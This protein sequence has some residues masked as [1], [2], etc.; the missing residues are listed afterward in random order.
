METDAINPKLEPLITIAL[1]LLGVVF[2]TSY[3]NDQSTHGAGPIARSVQIPGLLE[4]E[5]LKVLGKSRDFNFAYQSTDLFHDGAWSGNGHMFASNTELGDW[6]DFA[7]PVEKSGKYTV[8]AYLTRARD[9][10][11]VQFFVNEQKTGAIDLFDASIRST[12]P[13]SL[14][15]FSLSPKK[16]NLRIQVVGR[17]PQGVSPFYQFGIDGIRLERGRS[18]K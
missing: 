18:G 8:F 1:V 17:N 5:D 15:T 10:G 14:G 16:S 13:I 9:Y 4:A 7:V 6:I 2:T 11:V 12:G 3:L